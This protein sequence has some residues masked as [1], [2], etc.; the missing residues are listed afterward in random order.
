MGLNSKFSIATCLALFF[1]A[2][3]G[4]AQSQSPAEQGVWKMEQAY[5]AYQKAGNL[6]KYRSLFAP[7]F[8]GWCLSCSNPTGKDAIQAVL[9][10][11]LKSYTLEPGLSRSVGNAVVTCYQVVEISADQHGRATRQTIRITHTWIHSPDGWQ[12]VA[13]MASPTPKVG[14]GRVGER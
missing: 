5:W 2:V 13:G 9:G 1:C 3:Q 12:I 7:Q 11:R 10:S 14:A 8:I 6:E 4:T